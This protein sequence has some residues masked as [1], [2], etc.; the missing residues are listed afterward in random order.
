SIGAPAPDEVEEARGA[1]EKSLSPTPSLVDEIIRNC[2]FSPP[3]VSWVLLELELAGRLERH[4]G[5]KVSLI[6]GP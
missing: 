6:Q 5:N 1:I 2:Q 3:V 4:P